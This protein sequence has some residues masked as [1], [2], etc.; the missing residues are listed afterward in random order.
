MTDS[1]V[2]DIFL[3]KEVVWTEYENSQG[4]N[5]FQSDCE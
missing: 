1:L 4:V 3:P 2:M 5:T